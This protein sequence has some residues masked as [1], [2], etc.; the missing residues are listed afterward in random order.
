M[1]YLRRDREEECHPGDKRQEVSLKKKNVSILSNYKPTKNRLFG[2][3]PSLRLKVGPIAKPLM[4][5]RIPIL[6]SH[7][8]KTHFRLKGLALSFVLK[9][10]VLELDTDGLLGRLE[11]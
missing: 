1:K 7:V 9:V 2:V 11:S 5:K 8:N 10:R 3:A 4:Q 6:Y